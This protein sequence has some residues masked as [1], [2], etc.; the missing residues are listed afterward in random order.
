MQETMTPLQP[1][2]IAMHRIYNRNRPL[3]KVGLPRRR[4]KYAAKLPMAIKRQ[5]KAAFAKMKAQGDP[6]GTTQDNS[7]T[8]A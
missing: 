6:S 8:Q 1:E 7:G 3:P 5:M 2:D 4:V